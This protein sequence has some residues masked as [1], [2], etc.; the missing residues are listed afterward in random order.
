MYI[1]LQ[2]AQAIL[3]KFLIY[4]YCLMPDHFHI[5]ISPSIESGDVSNILQNFKSYTTQIGWKHGIIGKL[6]QKS[7]YD[8]I[9]RKEE[10]LIQICEY[11]LC[12]PVRRGLVEKA[13]DW[14]FSGML[15]PLPI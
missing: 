10:D 2:Y 12:N 4:C 6:W 8:H 9:A 15:D 11:I 5:S 14:P 13:E 1:L 3:K 7:F